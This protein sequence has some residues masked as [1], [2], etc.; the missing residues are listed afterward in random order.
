MKKKL[1]MPLI[2]V[3]GILGLVVVVVGGY[4][5]Y[6]KFFRPVQAYQ[7]AAETIQD[8]ESAEYDMV[9]D[10]TVSVKEMGMDMDMHLEG[11]GKIDVKNEEMQ[12]DMFIEFMGEK[13]D[14]SQVVVGDM[15]YMK[16]ADQPYQKMNMQE[17]LGQ[18]GMSVEQF[19]ENQIWSQYAD[20]DMEY[21][22][23]EELN[24]KEY[25]AY[26]LEVSGD[27]MDELIK[28]MMDN[29][30]DQNSQAEIEDIEI[31]N[32]NLKTWVD[33]ENSMPYKEKVKISEAT[34]SAGEPVGEMVMDMTMEIT[35]T[36]VNEPV[37]I[38]A[39]EM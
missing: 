17:A 7:K 27:A 38:E 4:L 18:G 2:A 16:I 6:T 9:T 11:E 25:Y 19:N 24:G 20:V 23:K 10:Y 29:L 37:N 34:F 22:G 26:S 8:F 32:V 33:P 13:I 5:G 39:P 21:L 28:N 35:Y 15:M 30:G 3:V 14:A 1:L 12:M 31:D 36:N